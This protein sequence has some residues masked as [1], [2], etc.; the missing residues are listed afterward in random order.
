MNRDR[1]KMYATLSAIS[2]AFGLVNGV[3]GT[4]YETQPAKVMVVTLLETLTE[5]TTGKTSTGVVTTTTTTTASSS[6]TASLPFAILVVA[7]VAALAFG[8]LWHRS[9]RAPIPQPA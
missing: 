6:A 8:I 7:F 9:K 4:Y 5:A 1:T 2:T 3:I